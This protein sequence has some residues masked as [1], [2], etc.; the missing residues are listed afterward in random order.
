MLRS[1]DAG[2]NWTDVTAG[3]PIRWVTR[4]TADPADAQTVYATLSGFGMDEALPHVY[5]STNRGSTWTSIAGNL[6]DVPANDIVVDPADPNR[7]FLATDV[8][9][10]VTPDLGGS[11]VPLG[12]GMPIQTIFDLT[13]HAPS[14]TLV[15][16]THGRSQWRVD[17]T[18]FPVVA[19]EP[20]VAP[21]RLSLSGPAPNPSRGSTELTLEL[22]RAGTIE[23]AV[24]DAAGRRVR[25]LHRGALA[26]G[27]HRLAWDGRDAR[28]G[29][30]AAGVY[31]VRALEGDRASAVRRLVRLS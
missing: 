30:V 9:V 6:P 12:T 26:A 22:S 20:G 7:L 1:I 15:A 29:R 5:R 28:G 27:R 16:A 24:F 2:A 17:L 23:V 21:A 8:G 11:W 25:D 10:Y 14:R 13:L 4:V 19:V 3:L 18:D 31:Y